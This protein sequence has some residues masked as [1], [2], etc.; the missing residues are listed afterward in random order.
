MKRIRYILLVFALLALAIPFSVA[1]QDQSLSLR[2]SRDWGYGGFNGDIQGLFTMHVTGPADLARVVF[3][4]DSTTIGEV[5]QAPF[6]L[7]FTT[8]SYPLGIHTLS[9]K[10]YSASGQ[11]YASNSIQANFV[12]P[13]NIGKMIFPILGIV[14]AAIL[15]SAFVPFLASRRTVKLPLGAER[16][17]GLRGGAICPKCHRPFPLP[18]FGAN[19]GFS[20]FVVCPYCGKASLVKPATIETLRQAERAELENAQMPSQQPPEG[21]QLKKDMDDSKYQDL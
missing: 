15:L 16:N 11:E 14:L 18:L 6:N 4:I 20:K 5:D 12:P 3:M 21:E 9:A 10:G 8:D 17:Y 2:L 7:Q 1:G 19:L 13:Q